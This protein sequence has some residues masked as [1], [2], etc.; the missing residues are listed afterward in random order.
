MCFQ[1]RYVSIQF[2]AYRKTHLAKKNLPAPIGPEQRA[3]L[4]GGTSNRSALAGGAFFADNLNGMLMK[5]CNLQHF[6]C[7]DSLP[8]FFELELCG[9]VVS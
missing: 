4:S 1:V 7:P 6:L 5:N 2:L 8:Q 9:K 3:Y